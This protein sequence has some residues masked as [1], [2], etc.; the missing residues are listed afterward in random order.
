MLLSHRYRF[1]FVHIAKTG[2]TS[3]RGAL[4]KY[5]WRDPYYLPQFIASKLSSI[6]RHEVGIKLPRHSKIIAARELLPHEFFDELFKFA[7]VRNPWDLQVSSYHHIKR[8]RPQL[9]LENESFEDFLSRKLDPQRPWQYHLDTSITPQSDYLIDL[10]GNVIA[11]FIGRYENLQEDFSHCC[12]RIGIPA[13]TLPHKR[14]ADDRDRY[15]SYYNDKTRD[16][17]AQHFARD[18]ELFDYAF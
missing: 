11:D 6:T 18:I 15:R 10:R 16:L 14:K 17:V 7:F 13:P 4:Q 1:L 8:E 3:V 12:E 5:R 9:L 2:G